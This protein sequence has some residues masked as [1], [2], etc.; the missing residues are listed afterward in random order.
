MAEAI[1]A[2]ILSAAFVQWLRGKRLQPV[3]HGHQVLLQL[4]V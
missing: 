1:W 2:I 4:P 3:T